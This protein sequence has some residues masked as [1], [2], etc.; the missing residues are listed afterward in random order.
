[1]VQVGPDSFEQMHSPVI[2]REKFFA[3]L[4][5]RIVVVILRCRLARGY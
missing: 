3:R 1:V 4:M 2:C 5:A